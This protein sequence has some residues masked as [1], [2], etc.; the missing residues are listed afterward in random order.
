MPDTHFFNV[1]LAVRFGQENSVIL[2]NL[3][4]WIRHNAQNNINFFEGRFWT[5]NTLNAFQKQFP[6]F[7]V[8]QIRTILNNLKKSGAVLTGNFNR[9]AFD[10]TLWYSVSDEVFSIYEGKAAEP[11]ATPDGGF[12][13][14]GDGKSA[15]HTAPPPD[16]GGSAAPIC[17]NSQMRLGDST[18]AFV[19]SHGPIPDKNKNIL[20]KDINRD[21]TATPAMVAADSFI[22]D[23]KAAFSGIDPLLL[24]DRAF[25]PKAR[26]VLEKYGLDHKYLAWLYDFC[27]KKKPDDL[28]AYYFRVFGEE[29]LINRFLSVRAPPETPHV[30]CP[31]CGSNHEKFAVCPVCGFS[32]GA[33]VE[34][35]RFIFNM[36]ED[37]RAAYEKEL[38]A[39]IDVSPFAERL[40]LARAIRLKYGIPE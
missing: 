40:S 8:N 20:N 36:P 23:L 6:Y 19:E 27:R 3:C 9:V 21:S 32:G 2:S 5:Y 38:A 16:D 22:N 1:P 14:D 7:T 17:E 37:A 4:Y 12:A 34:T 11:A 29:S 24:F 13:A 26:S 18:N 28:T 33:K 39:V 25:Y 15:A 35:A 30:V 10:R 31:V